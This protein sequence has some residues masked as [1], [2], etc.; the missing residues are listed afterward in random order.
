MA[1]TGYLAAIDYT[2]RDFATIKA[3]LVK[4][5]QNHFPNDFT[6][7]TSSNL[8][9][10]ILELVAYVGD[11]LSFYLDRVVNEIFLPTVV[12]RQNAINLVALLGYTP[13][14]TAAALAPLQMTL[15]VAQTGLV[16][17]PSWTTFTDSGGETWELLRNYEIP[18]GRTDT[19]DIAVTAEVLTVAD[20]SLVYALS[21]DNTN[22]VVGTATLYLTMSSVTYSI[23]VG[24]DG[25]VALPFG[26]TGLLD[27]S[28]GT[29]A[30][31]FLAGYT[32][33]TG[34]NIALDYDW[35]QN[36]VAYHGKTR[37]EQ[38]ISDGTSNQRFA[39]TSTPVLFS[40]R[41]EDVEVTPNPNRFEVWMGD[42]GD[43]YGDSTGTMWRRIDSLVSATDT[44]EVYSLSLDD[45]DRVQIQF[46]DGING[47]VPSSGTI[48]VI[49]RVGGGVKGN[50]STGYIDTT[51]TGTV[52]LFA[53]TVFVYNYEQGSG[54]AERE[55]LDEIRV[56][57]PAYFRTNN[58][59]T[60][61]QDYDALALYSQ[62]GIGT[63]ARAKSRLTPEEVVTTK[64]IHSG[65]VIGEVPVTTPVEYY[66][67]LPATP[68]DIS[69]VIVTYT[70]AGVLRTVTGAAVG[71]VGWAN[72]TG[73][74][75]VD[76]AN[77]RFYSVE[78][79]GVS[80][81]PGGFVGNG[82]TINFSAASP[83][84]LLYWPVLP[85][86][87]VFRYTIGTTVY[88]GYDDGAG[89]LLG[90]K[91]AGSTVDYDDGALALHFGTHGAITCV[92]A[93][94]FNFNA[95]AAGGDVFLR[96]GS[97]GAYQNV[98]FQPGDAA[99]YAAVTAAE[100]VVVLNTGGVTGA[101]NALSGSVAS[102]SG[103]HITITSLTYGTTSS[104][105]VDIY[106]G[107]VADANNLANGLGF[108]LL[109]GSGLSYPPD[110]SSL[111]LF[112]YQSC[113]HLVLA[114]A[115]DSGSEIQ[116]S[117]ESGPSVKTFP[118][119]NIEVYTWAT[120]VAGTFGDPGEA[121]KDSLKAYLDLRR[122]LGTS[123][124]VLDGLLLSLHY[125]LSVVFSDNSDSV[126][127]SADIVTAVEAYFDSVVEVNAG[128]LVPI[129]AIYDA[130]YPLQ[131][132]ES[133]VIQ[134]V[135]V[136]VRVGMGTAAK[137]TFRND[138]T[139]TIPGQYIPPERLPMVA[140]IGTNPSS[141]VRILVDDE[142]VATSSSAYPV[143]AF[144]TV[145]G[146][147]YS[148]LGG[149]FVNLVT[150]AFEIKTS[151][152]L[153]RGA[154]LYIDYVLDEVA[155]GNQSEIWNV[156]ANEWEIA[157]LADMYVNDNKVR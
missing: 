18:A 46:G 43:P 47:K 78:Q 132:V 137:S 118:S 3:A 16:T 62:S 119:N 36:I 150:G 88:T 59:A 91:L 97:D 44:E 56:N 104:V 139:Q 66:L 6:D 123:V 8:G 80:E 25:T 57:A 134:D 109:P 50:V 27:Y 129:A 92:K 116:I 38:F 13:R 67:L 21:T 34:T 4:H 75:T 107:G 152:P 144:T 112:D 121:L 81:N 147:S 7:F 60:T 130:V 32:A 85:G 51:V 28:L 83:N 35:N 113:L 153:S 42:P 135:G 72:L 82:T 106:G 131:G 11:Q 125:H 45:Q 2:A 14:T 29:L 73:D 79:N 110:A 124:Q 37:I 23:D 9:V 141:G 103:G 22:I 94:P 117:M 52:G 156:Q 19:T 146:A 157:I 105:D 108:S 148:I 17:V 49:Y 69:S 71:T 20:G 12:Q 61:E 33:T 128:S 89:N 93:T 24:D 70:V 95:I 65:V 77:T 115:P 68:I 15:D 101:G 41:V 98:R 151:P 143:V 90:T 136:R 102:T 96:V 111:I 39:L 76:S 114:F 120:T 58:T 149:S 100:V 40:S 31:Q 84:G 127:T 53:V 54:G 1:T 154:K 55:S 140:G 26:G 30:L 142:V 145:L 126:Q 133:V 10:C 138:A 155:A 86:S 74:A 48:N 5:V 122:V 87:I 99:A 63:V 64:T